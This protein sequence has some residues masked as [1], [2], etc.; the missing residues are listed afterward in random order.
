M[1]GARCGYGEAGSLDFRGACRRRPCAR[2]C[3]FI[4]ATRRFKTPI[5][6]RAIPWSFAMERQLRV[7]QESF[8]DEAR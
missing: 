4:Q 1:S 7:Q 2:T 3:R 6:P 8:E 5:E